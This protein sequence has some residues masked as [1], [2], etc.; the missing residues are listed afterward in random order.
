M[1]QIRVRCP[2]VHCEKHVKIDMK[3]IVILIFGG[4]RYILCYKHYLEKFF[5]C[6]CLTEIDPKRTN[7][8]SS[9]NEHYY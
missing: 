5:S 6:Y 3:I 4:K 9:L 2:V 7:C 8:H 1:K